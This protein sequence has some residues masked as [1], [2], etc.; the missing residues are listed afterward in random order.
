MAPK[1]RSWQQRGVRWGTAPCRS[2][3]TLLATIWA[4]MIWLSPAVAP[5]AADGASPASGKGASSY[6][7]GTTQIP[8]PLCP[9][10]HASP[11]AGH[12]R[13][14]SA[15]VTVADPLE[16]RLGR[17]FDLQIAALIR[18]FH[19]RGFVLDGYALTWKL[20]LTQS[21]DGGGLIPKDGT[22]DFAG[23][24]RARPSV[25]V[26]RKD[27]WR[28][29]PA[30]EPPGANG[31]AGLPLAETGAE[32]FLTFLV[33]DSPTSGVH[34]SA[35]R[36]AATC[37]ALL[38]GSVDAKRLFLPCTGEQGA[39]A[40][41]TDAKLEVIGPAFS[42]SMDSVALELGSMLAEA[43]GLGVD[44]I[45]PSASVKSNER[46]PEW[47]ETIAGRRAKVTYNSLAASLEDQ[48]MALA[49]FRACRGISGTVT[50]LAEESAFGHGVDELLKLGPGDVRAD[51]RD[52]AQAAWADLVDNARVA[53]FPQNIAAIRSEH[54][55]IERD[56]SESLRKALQAQS[57]LLELDLSGIGETVDRPP[58][59]QRELAPGPT[60]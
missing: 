60:S 36:T 47:T 54:S 51:P 43:P 23:Q 38:S 17:A 14:R 28:E 48:L 32:Y 2:G 33:G 4:A 41:A 42:G 45:S 21:A 44:L 57:R 5:A 35:F 12:I 7:L 1:A 6:L 26:F 52:R 25:L 29:P 16:T 55:S 22:G 10:S 30:S 11:A 31:R 9:L 59:Y 24:Q 3:R 20:S 27:L 40:A 56:R 13:V 53:N 8:D 18:A 37:A 15:V 58:A 46:V 49:D 50:I 19:A 39:L 34:P